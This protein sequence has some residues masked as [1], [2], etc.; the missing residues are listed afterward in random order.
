MIGSEDCPGSSGTPRSR[1]RGGVTLGLRQTPEIRSVSSRCQPAKTR[2]AL[3]WQRFAVC[4]L[5]PPLSISRSSRFR[6]F[7]VFHGISDVSIWDT[8]DHNS[9]RFAEQNCPLFSHVEERT[10]LCINMQTSTLERHIR[11]MK[12]ILNEQN[13][14]HRML[15]IFIENVH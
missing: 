3:Q 4:L 13:F 12:T 1:D 15:L 2:F 6:Y 11:L 5:I 14:E 8:S 7:T 10:R 9:S